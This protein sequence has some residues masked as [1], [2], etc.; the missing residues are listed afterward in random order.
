MNCVAIKL[1]IFCLIVLLLKFCLFCQKGFFKLAGMEKCHELLNCSDLKSIELL[2]L[3]GVGAVK[4]VYLA[5][6]HGIELCVSVVNN[7]RFIDDFNHGMEM[8]RCLNPNKFVV[9]L[10]GYCENPLFVL[11]EFHK[12]GDA[13]NLLNLLRTNQSDDLTS[14]LQV[15]LNYAKLLRFLH[16]SPCG[17]RV[18]CDSNDLEKLLSQILLSNDLQLVWN[19]LDALPAADKGLIRCGRNIGSSNF[20]APE[21]LGSQGYNEK[22]DIWKAAHLCEYFLQDF[23]DSLEIKNIHTR[24]RNTNVSERLTAVE[25]VEL[26]RKS[27]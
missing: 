22:S 23:E 17:V 26:Y 6:W 19:D 20:V 7:E 10:V 9:Q 16:N 25:L 1:T 5:K 24:C 13:R 18:M 14:R 4:A 3:I 11:T 27:Y 12:N 21:Q 15:C 2:N 8:L